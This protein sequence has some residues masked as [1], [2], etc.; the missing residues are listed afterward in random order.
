[1][2]IDSKS[3][4]CLWAVAASTDPTPST[5]HTAAAGTVPAGTVP[6]RRGRGRVVSAVNT[7]AR[8]CDQSAAHNAAEVLPPEG[9]EAALLRWMPSFVPCADHVNRAVPT[10]R[11]PDEGLASFGPGVT[12]GFELG[13][14]F[15]FGL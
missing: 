5:G 13:L 1:V 12:F 4:A 10:R 8:S 11:A 7:S 6:T 2:K 3:Q 15:R 14:E 9:F